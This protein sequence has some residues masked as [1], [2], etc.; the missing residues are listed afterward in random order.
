[1]KNSSQKPNQTWARVSKPHSIEA[2]KSYSFK[3]PKPTTEEMY[4]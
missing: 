4:L 3:T 1:M 2:N